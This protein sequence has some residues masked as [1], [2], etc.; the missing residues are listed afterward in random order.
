MRKLIISI[1][2]VFFLPPVVL[3]PGEVA[4]GAERSGWY[5]YIYVGVGEHYKRLVIGQ[6]EQAKEGYDLLWESPV[7]KTFLSAGVVQPYFYHP[8]WKKESP[9]FWRDIRPA[10][11][12]PR[13]W[14]FVVKTKQPNVELKFKWDLSRVEKGIRLYLKIKEDNIKLH[15]KK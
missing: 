7:P 12:L 2:F 9:F 13:I 10:G 3:A 11:G 8:E 1:L 14:E 15:N 5:A 4:F 6:N